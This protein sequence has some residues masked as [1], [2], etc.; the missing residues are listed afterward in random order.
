MLIPAR[1]IKPAS[2]ARRMRPATLHG[3]ILV[4]AGPTHEPIDCVRYIGNRSSGRLGVALAAHAASRGLRVTLLLGPVGA[5]PEPLGPP[6]T[7]VRVIRFRTT[8]DL[9]ALL[10]EQ[11]P[12][13]EALIMAAAVADYR[14]KASAAP[15]APGAATGGKIPR[16]AQGLTL[17]LEATPDL[18]A[19]CGSA[20]AGSGK[21]LVGFALEPRERMRESARA[22]LARKRVHAIV[23]NPL[24]TMDAPSIEAEVFW[25]DGAEDRT[26]GSISKDEFARWLLDRMVAHGV[27]RQETTP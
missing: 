6:D 14:P 3:T 11:L 24:E 18:L 8:A 9:Q 2:G 21:T 26:P 10:R 22:K 13:H 15:G 5:V 25:A 27:W 17:E 1:S 4:T 19:E 7:S 16:S 20:F 23:A 12:L